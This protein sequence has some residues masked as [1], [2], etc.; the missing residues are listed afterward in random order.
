MAERNPDC[1]LGKEV[2]PKYCRG[3]CSRCGWD[4]EVEAARNAE[5]EANG[6]TKGPDGIRR[7]IIR[8]GV[9]TDG[10]T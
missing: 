2:S 5:I 3:V 4:P 8:K 7:L 1:K 10:N 9:E 6:L